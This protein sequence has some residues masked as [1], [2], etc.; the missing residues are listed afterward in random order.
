MSESSGRTSPSEP[1]GR[2]GRYQRSFGGLIGA[3]LVLIVAVVGFI[4]V[5]EALRTTPEFEVDPVDH[6]ELVQQIQAGGGAV[7][8]PAPLPDGWV[9]KNADYTPGERPAWFLAMDTDEGSVVQLREE[10]DSQDRLVE[11]HLG[12]PDE[13]ETV[14]LD[15]GIDGPW[16]TWSADD[17]DLGY[18]TTVGDRSVLIYGSASAEEQEELIS[19]LTTEPI[20]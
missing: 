12:S 8:H 17:G 7:V 10:H 4:A 9:V 6:R 2:P 18:S 15:S 3:M 5:R 13:G 1:S 20:D 19:R 11:E 16:R 14:A